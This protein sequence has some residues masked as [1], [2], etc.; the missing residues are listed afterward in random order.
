M[1]IFNKL[2]VLTDKVYGELKNNMLGFFPH[3]AFKKATKKKVF[4]P[5]II[6]NQVAITLLNN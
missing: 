6:T 5:A 3:K 4:L 2:V 1:S